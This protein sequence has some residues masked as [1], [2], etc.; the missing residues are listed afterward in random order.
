MARSPESPVAPRVSAPDIP[1]ALSP[2][3]PGRSADLLACRLALSGEVDLAHATLEQCVVTAD[4][5]TVVMTGAR[6]MDVEISDARVASLSLREA[7]IRRLRVAGGRI[8][9]LDLSGARMD[10]LE[11]RDLRIDYLNLG[12]ARAADVQVTNC[13]IRTLDLPQAQLTR[14]RFDGCDSHEVDTRGLRATDVDLRGLDAMAYTDA[15]S[16]RGTTLSSFQVQQLATTLA[17]AVGIQIKD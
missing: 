9:T 15:N 14:V 1:D 2:A 5:D 3:E 12:A 11:L 17:G 4:A 7:A 6:V 10:E 16:L 8:G 13:T